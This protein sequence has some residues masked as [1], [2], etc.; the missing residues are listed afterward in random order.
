MT[1][2]ALSQLLLLI[3]VA[4]RLLEQKSRAL[5]MEWQLRGRKVF[6]SSVFKRI[7]NW[8]SSCCCLRKI[9][10]INTLPLFIPS[11]SLKLATGRLLLNTSIV[12]RTTQRISLLTWV[13]IWTLAF[14]CFLSLVILSWSGFDTI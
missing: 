5:L 3:W 11:R 7:P 14:L 4:V 13:T 6:A 12:K 9:S 1:M 8:Q 2:V 10:I